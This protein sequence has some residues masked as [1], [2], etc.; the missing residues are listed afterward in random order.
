MENTD[1]KL[2]QTIAKPKPIIISTGA[3]DFNEIK[4]AI[5]IVNKFHNKLIILHCV[6][7]YPTPLNDANLSRIIKLKK[8]SKK[9]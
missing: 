5:K 6:S 9:I 2:I 1:V 8:I 3:S 4:R 7:K